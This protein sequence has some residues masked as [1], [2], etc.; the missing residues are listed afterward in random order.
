MME[1]QGRW[2]LGVNGLWNWGRNLVVSSGVQT[3]G[4]RIM[5]DTFSPPSHI[6]FGSGT[7]TPLM[8]DV[9]LQAEQY[10]FDVVAGGGL[11]GQRLTLDGKAFEI[12][13]DTN[14]QITYSGTTFTASEC[15][16]FGRAAGKTPVMYSRFLVQDFKMSSGTKWRMA[17]T[18]PFEEKL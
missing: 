6:V 2:E 1:F 8:T 17:W 15:G 13:L 7:D 9:G 10:S 14:G 12:F 3:F 11:A 18:L 16:V 4:R 5:G